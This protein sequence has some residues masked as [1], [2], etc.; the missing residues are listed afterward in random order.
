MK[1]V[2]KEFNIGFKTPRSDACNDCAL[3]EKWI[4]EENDPEKKKKLERYLDLHKRNAELC[5]DFMFWQFQKSYAQQGKTYQEW[6]HL[7]FH[8]EYVD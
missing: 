4:A 3:L 6:S 1:Y 5:Q 8:E 7:E 2:R